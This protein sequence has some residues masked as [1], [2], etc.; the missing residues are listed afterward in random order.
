MTLVQFFTASGVLAWCW[1]AWRSYQSVHG[2][3][4]RLRWA[5]GG[6]NRRQRWRPW[7]R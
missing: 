4:S 1:L 7:R 5:V 3:C 2:V 6:W